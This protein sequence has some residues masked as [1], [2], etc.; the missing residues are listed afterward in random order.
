VPAAAEVGFGELRY[1]DVAQVRF[2]GDDEVAVQILLPT[3]RSATVRGGVT[4]L[5]EGPLVSAAARSDTVTLP[6]AR[7]LILRGDVAGSAR[8]QGT[9]ESGAALDEL[10][11]ISQAVS[12]GRGG[13]AG[14]TVASFAAVTRVEAMDDFGALSVE[15]PHRYDTPDIDGVVHSFEP[16]RDGAEARPDGHEFGRHT[17]EIEDLDVGQP[18]THFLVVLS[19][20]DAGA[21]PASYSLAEGEGLVAAVS[22]DAA[23]VFT[24]DRDVDA[25]SVDLPAEVTKVVILGLRANRQYQVSMS[26][27]LSLAPDAG[28]NVCASG[29]GTLE[30]RR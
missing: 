25:G 9:D 12:D 6:Q 2:R 19:M 26:G 11:S 29:A 17:L 24:L 18:T 30:I 8:V 23:W 21:T 16:G 20:A 3:H 22:G 15:I 7:W 10:V 4:T 27:T 28:G 14:N 1:G 5:S 13:F